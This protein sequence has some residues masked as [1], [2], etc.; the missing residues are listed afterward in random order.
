MP[1]SLN[2]GH[3]PVPSSSQRVIVRNNIGQ[4]DGIACDWITMKL[5]WTDSVFRRIEVADVEGRFRKVL[6]GN[7]MDL[8]RSIAVVANNN[9]MFWTDWGEKPKLERASMDGSDRKVI[10]SGDIGW[11]NGIAVDP[12]EPR[13][14]YSDARLSALFSMDFD[15]NHR[16]NVLKYE[17]HPYSV[18]VLDNYIYW[19]DWQNN[20]VFTT[21]KRG[22][23]SMRKALQDTHLTTL[24]IKF[25]ASSQQRGDLNTP[26][27]HNNGGCSALC[28]LSTNPS[29]MS[30]ACPTGVRLQSDNK[31]CEE[32][33]ESMFFVARK[34]DIQAI[35]LDTSDHTIMALPLRDI[36]HAIAVDFDPYEG[37]LFWSDDET[38]TINRAKLD[39]T[40]QQ[41]I[42]NKDIFLPDGIAIDSVA[43]NIYFT[44]AESG[45]IH[46]APLSGSYRKTIISSGLRKPRAIAV[47]SKAGWVYWT[48]WGLGVVE[49]S[50]LDGRNRETLVH[51]PHGWPN[52]LAL[53]TENGKMYWGDAKTALIEEANMDGTGRVVLLEKIYHIFGLALYNGYLYWSEWKL[54]RLERY[55]LDTRARE[56][57]AANLADVMLVWAGNIKKPPPGS[58]NPCYN[59]GG[60]S[61]FCLNT[62]RGKV[63]ACPD[64][65]TLTDDAK[66]CEL[67]KPVLLAAS[68]DGKLM[69]GLVGANNTLL[70]EQVS[71]ITEVQAVG[72]IE[73]YWTD[74]SLYFVDSI[75]RIIYRTFVERP[76]RV[77][78]VVKNGLER[79]SGLAV[80]WLAGNLYWADSE[81]ARIEVSRLN[82]AHRR[83]IL[84]VEMKP[85][86][87]VVDPVGK[88]LYWVDIYSTA[89]IDRSRLD[90][91]RRGKLVDI[92]AQ[93]QA[94]SLDPIGRKLYWTDGDSIESVELSG[95][96][97]RAVYSSSRTRLSQ[98]AVHNGR[99][100]LSNETHVWTSVASRPDQNTQLW[101]R[102]GPRGVC[103]LEV[104]Q[105]PPASAWNQCALSNGECQ[106]LCFAVPSKEK[107]FYCSCG[108]HYV[109]DAQEG[110]CVLPRNMILFAQ[111]T[112]IGRLPLNA[113]GPD[114]L[115]PISTRSVRSL[116]YDP[117]SGLIYWLDPTQEQILRA[118]DDGSA[119]EPAFKPSQNESRLID[120]TLDPLTGQL[121]WICGNRNTINVARMMPQ[122]NFKQ[123]GVIA[124]LDR[125]RLIAVHQQ[126]SLVVFLNT[127]AGVNKIMS[128]SYDGTG[129]K[130][131]FNGRERIKAPTD[132]VVDTRS[133]LVIWAD[134]GPRRVE[135]V[136][137]DGDRFVTLLKDI[138][139]N[140]L[141]VFE[142]AVIGL[143]RKDHQIFMFDKN[144][145]GKKK[146]LS[147]HRSPLVDVFAVPST[148][149]AV[150][151]KDCSCSHV[152]L[153]H[154]QKEVKF[155]CSCPEEHS[156]GSCDVAT[157]SPSEWTCRGGVNRCIPL[158]A[159]CDGTFDCS[160]GSDEYGCCALM[161]V[162][163]CSSNG[164]LDMCVH[165]KRVCDG[166]ADCRDGSDE[167]DCEHECHD[168]QCCQ[169][170]FRCQKSPGKYSCLPPEKICNA[171]SDCSDNTDEISCCPNG[172]FQCH[173]RSGCIDSSKVC[174]GYR[175]CA[176]GSDEFSCCSDNCR[177]L[178]SKSQDIAVPAADDS[179]LSKFLIS[180]GVIVI[181]IIGVG[182]FFAKRDPKRDFGLDTAMHYQVQP[183]SL[184][185]PMMPLPVMKGPP[186]APSSAASSDPNPST[187]P[188]NPPPS[189]ATTQSY[190]HLYYNRGPP[191]RSGASST[192]SSSQI[193]MG[194]ETSFIG[195]QRRNNRCNFR[196]P[197]T[198]CS[199]EEYD[200]L[201][202]ERGY[203]PPPASPI[204][205]TEKALLYGELSP[206]PSHRDQGFV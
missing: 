60:C 71:Q 32:E 28:L 6:I 96:S 127:E 181:V 122:G 94:I 168:E 169:K 31:T 48:D 159:R 79:V 2:G 191:M 153:V 190:D 156:E 113:D 95:K 202:Y 75:K 45:R 93:A 23:G 183:Q 65:M 92:K 192:C 133:D 144:G 103:E 88:Q 147:S 120:F 84:W 152:C 72:A 146:L 81:L 162:F 106:A 21:P 52:G 42:I 85:T 184:N 107:S 8:P 119:F 131:I 36:K 199:A 30:C 170:S 105:K 9:I 166:H 143:N 161:D 112:T 135:S 29:G 61:H 125:P 132:L 15:G 186:A 138:E 67:E 134:I 56:I 195:H 33:I 188:H 104:L 177:T 176:D 26:C 63:C 108:T 57:M 149:P 14:Y 160:D 25:Y 82:G 73:F 53:D 158:E 115:L 182:T 3:S 16:T 140:S 98:M 201:C 13:V 123:L 44:D 58:D 148:L 70:G 55:K 20:S 121:F 200:S 128:C 86:L 66:S 18:V 110:R 51:N 198:P 172:M 62:P 39:G 68:S 5:Y 78:A 1:T 69:H 7:D 38:K 101:Q 102:Q 180:F 99:L 109:P 175:Q 80:D 114:I 54:S 130:T 171:E 137:L 37:F 197:N 129:L 77:E 193:Y 165:S 41:I 91:S 167:K 10:V 22:L 179:R 76:A 87:L 139:V 47:D 178:V 111:K 142:D 126:K 24:D 185:A 89:R 12:D 173:N 17:G 189:P 206:N 187:Y 74:K 90:G 205:T 196:R 27:N 35:S 150:K 136:H 141:A 34:V 59:G 145:D 194:S 4:I 116:H 204:P 49:R 40:E 155:S 154:G 203:V 46:V 83:V 43:R 64:N 11:P 118:K 124:K 163:K 100:F 164:E 50:H 157:C 19:T 97:R 174:D 117:Y 151:P